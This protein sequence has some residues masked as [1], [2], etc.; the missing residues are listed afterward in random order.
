MEG[1][2]VAPGILQNRATAFVA[3]A[4]SPT[5]LHASRKTFMVMTLKRQPTAFISSST[6]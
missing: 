2:G 3:L 6:L 1:G 4:V 5:L